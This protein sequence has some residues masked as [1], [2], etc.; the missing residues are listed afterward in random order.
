MRQ[1]MCFFFGQNRHQLKGEDK[2]LSLL[3]LSIQV[4]PSTRCIKKQFSF[5]SKPATFV[6]P[7]HLRPFVPSQSPHHT[8]AATHP[9]L[10]ARLSVCNGP[11]V[12][13]KS[14]EV[15]GM[16]QEK[17]TKQEELEGER[18]KGQKDERG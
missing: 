13:G 6:G 4:C 16:E 10:S 9:R 18:G 11:D 7:L 2:G 3:C 5:F 8:T 1:M 14:K 15:R 17:E 12:G